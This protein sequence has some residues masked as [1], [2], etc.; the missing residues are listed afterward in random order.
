MSHCYLF[1]HYG[2][3]DTSTVEKHQIWTLGYGGDGEEGA[4]NM[5][6]SAEC[7]MPQETSSPSSMLPGNLSTGNAELILC[8]SPTVG[9]SES[10]LCGKFEFL[11]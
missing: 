4:R 3:Y 10:M 5:I 7:A 8:G 1:T 11:C 9:H 2:Q 6:H